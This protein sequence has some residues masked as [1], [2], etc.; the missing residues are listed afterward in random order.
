MIAPEV[1]KLTLE[2]LQRAEMKGGEVDAYV[3]CVRTLQQEYQNL[4]RPKEEN[5][6]EPEA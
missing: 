6:N 3:T 2:F 1:L 4:T 5:T